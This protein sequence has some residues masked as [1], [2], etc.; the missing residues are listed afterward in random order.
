MKK[1]AL[2]LFL[3][4]LLAAGCSNPEPPSDMEIREIAWNYLGEAQ[5]FVI[6]SP[7][8]VVHQDNGTGVYTVINKARPDVWKQ[9]NVTKVNEKIREVEFVTDMGPTIVVDVDVKKRK[10]IKKETKFQGTVIIN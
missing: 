5:D 4:T 8:D 9:A 10:A 6:G 1:T 7:N 3:V 2:I